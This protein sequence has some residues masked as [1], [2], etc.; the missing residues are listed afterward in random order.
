MIE[1]TE[2]I[3]TGVAGSAPEGVWDPGGGIEFPC[4]YVLYGAKKYREI[5]NQ[6]LRK[7]QKSRK[8][9]KRRPNYVPTYVLL[10]TV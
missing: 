1:R 4:E 7:V 10:F 6:T 9:K 2:G 3:L 5:V 8:R